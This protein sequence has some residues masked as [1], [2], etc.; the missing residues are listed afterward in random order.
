MKRIF[1]QL[2][3]VANDQT[4]TTSTK[5]SSKHVQ[6]EDDDIIYVRA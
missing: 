6:I 2:P 3:D 4:D 5:S 1:Q